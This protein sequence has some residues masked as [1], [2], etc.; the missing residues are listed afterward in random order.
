MS[1]TIIFVRHGQSIANVEGFFAGQ[2]D[3]PLTNVGITQAK[4]TANYIKQNYKVYKV[5]ASDL[6]RAYNTGV[7]IAKECSCD[8]VANK[9]FREIF[10]G[11]WQ[12]EKFENLVNNYDCYQVWL[13]DIGK[14][15]SCG[16]ESVKQVGERIY[17]ETL[18]LAKENENQTIV[19]VTHAL[20]IRTLKS[21]IE[22]NSLDNMKN[23]SWPSNSS[24]SVLECNGDKFSFIEYS[25]DS[26]LGDIKSNFNKNV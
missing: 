19:I 20:P 10:A 17:K 21:R 22:Y 18:R 9:S 11:D 3:A 7:I 2:I 15:V 14:A 6:S 12:G 16:G 26:F 5:Y 1:T 24:I 23:I 13:K 8:I 4:L 25:I